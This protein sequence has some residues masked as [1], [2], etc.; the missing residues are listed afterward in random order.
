M[1]SQGQTGL[2]LPKQRPRLP[3]KRLRLPQRS[4]FFVS[5]LMRL[6][7]SKRLLYHCP[8]QSCFKRRVGGSTPQMPPV[9][10]YATVDDIRLLTK[11]R[12]GNLANVMHGRRRAQPQLPQSQRQKKQ[13]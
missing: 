5:H 13:N 8:G 6:L 11:P 10:A 3:L 1:P 7:H 4:V 2:L 12:S 9:Q